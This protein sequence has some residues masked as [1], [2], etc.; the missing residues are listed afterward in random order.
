MK[1]L[2]AAVELIGPVGVKFALLGLLFEFPLELVDSLEPTDL[3]GGARFVLAGFEAEVTTVCEAGFS[4]GLGL[5]RDVF[6]ALLSFF[7]PFFE[8]GSEAGA[9]G[10][11]GLFYPPCPAFA[12][13]LLAVLELGTSP[14]SVSGIERG[15]EDR[16]EL[17]MLH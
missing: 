15:D 12:A 7:F 5:E 2:Q 8:G 1:K 6:L 11:L 3:V 13:G 4:A 9:A 16:E 10:L 14:L 17:G